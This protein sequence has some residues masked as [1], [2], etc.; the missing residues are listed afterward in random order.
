MYSNSDQ[1][2]KP[3]NV[4]QRGML[5]YDKRQMSLKDEFEAI[6][7]YQKRKIQLLTQ[8][9]SQQTIDGL[10]DYVFEISSPLLK[11]LEFPM[12]IPYSRTFCGQKILQSIEFWT[13][14]QI[15]FYLLN[16]QSNYY[17]NRLEQIFKI[18]L[19]K[20]LTKEQIINTHQII[21]QIEQVQDFRLNFEK[22]CESNKETGKPS[23]DNNEI[24]SS[25]FS[26]KVN[27]KRLKIIINTKD[28][29]SIKK[30]ELEDQNCFQA[31]FEKV[32]TESTKNDQTTYNDLI[33]NQN[34]IQQEF[35]KDDSQKASLTQEI[36]ELVRETIN[37]L[38]NDDNN[39]NM[40][41]NELKETEIQRNE[42]FQE[43]INQFISLENLYLSSNVEFVVL[44]HNINRNNSNSLIQ[45]L[46]G[47]YEGQFALYQFKETL[48]E[49]I[50]KED[51]NYYQ[52]Y[53]EYLKVRQERPIVVMHQSQQTKEK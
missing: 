14:Y 42:N 35:I 5:S 41:N 11:H 15:I 1:K 28:N 53:L 21:E 49:K 48:D 44:I 19:H 32:I 46:E 9:Q 20:Y 16:Q 47:D 31:N 38:I 8:F 51:F 4:H 18:R 25:Q 12:Q 10:M 27:F 13:L 7:D 50:Q 26:K 17:F 6:L 23:K 37:D 39:N 30:E 3:K 29:Q 33:Q 43:Q 36:K 40:N 45:V 24:S 34:Q 22:L 52:N 2:T